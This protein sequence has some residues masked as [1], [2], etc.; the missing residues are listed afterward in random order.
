MINKFLSWPIRRLLVM[1]IFLLALPTLFLIARSGIAERNNAIDEAERECLRLVNSM[2]TEQQAVVDG[3]QQ[4]ATALAILPDIRL[5]NREATNAVLAEHVKKN[6]RYSNIVLG[7]K[8]GIIWASA[9]PF[10]G[11]LSMADRK[12]YQDAVRTGMFSSGE[13][14]IGKVAK[15]RMMSFGYPVKNASNQLVAVIGIALDLDYPQ[16]IFEKFSLPPGASFSLLDH[17]G[18]ILI[19]NI[20]DL[21]SEKLVGRRDTREEL[22]TK[23]KEGPDEGTY[24]AIGNDGNFRLTAY[25]KLSLPH[26]S[27]PYLYVR[28]SIPLASAT[29]KANAVMFKNLTLL[30]LLFG[31]VLFLTWFIGKRVI[32]NPIMLLQK[33]SEQLGAGAGTV[34]AS[35]LV[36]GGEL[37]ELARAFDAMADAVVQ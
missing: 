36:K 37:G 8:S 4:L 22:F 34:N 28:S 11:K 15:K 19:R 18:I 16:Q 9:V 23:M 3:V 24:E 6:P 35:H 12:Y 31:A 20:K 26:E 13:Y 30:V 33:A 27:K 17:Q 1:L 32:V 25:K 10:E 5:G 7:D 29:A 2:A 14:N 21:V